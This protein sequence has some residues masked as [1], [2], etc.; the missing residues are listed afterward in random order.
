MTIVVH[1]FVVTTGLFLVGD[2]IKYLLVSA[3]AS[4]WPKQEGTYQVDNNPKTHTH[5]DYL[6]LRLRTLKSNLLVTEDHLHEHLNLRY[7]L[8]AVDL[9]L[10]G[11]YFLLLMCLV[12]V[13]QD[14]LL[15]YNT[16]MMT[17]LFS[18]NQ[19]YS[20]GLNY[21][22]SLYQTY[23][24]IESA[25]INSFN[26]N[27]TETGTHGWIYGD[28]NSKLGVV[29]LRQIRRKENYHLGWNGIRYTSLAYMPKWEL[30]YKRMA[31]TDKYW[32]IY[33]PWLPSSVTYTTFE[34]KFMNFDH[35]G[36]F[37]DYPE[38]A[39][40]ITMLAR[41][42]NNSMKVLNYLQANNWLTKETIV[43][44]LD[45]TLYNA[46]ANIFS[47]CTFLL[48]QTPFGT[49]NTDAH[50][51]SVKMQILDQLGTLG[52]TIAG[53][54]AFILIRF[55][56]TLVVTIWYE[57]AK[58]HNMWNKM[59][60]VILLLN[61]L[62]A[63]LIITQEI[64]VSHLLAKVEGA[65]KLEFLDFRRPAR[66]H[67][68]SS[69]MI[70]FLVCLTTLRLWKVLQFANVFQLFSAALYS[71][72]QA[73][74]S[75]AL[76]IVIFL[77]AFGFAV[78]II[79]GNNTGNFIHIYRSIITSLCFS[80]GF[81][82]H[83][84]PQ[85]LF[86]GGEIIGLILYFLLAFVLAQLLINVFVSTI[87]GYFQYAKSFRDARYV[88][89]INFL[90]FLRVEY[91]HILNHLTGKP[92]FY[93]SYHRN[94]RTVAENI[95]II[96]DQQ[97]RSGTKNR[98]H[99]FATSRQKTGDITDEVKKQA[100]YKRRIGRLF[101]IASI[102]QTQMEILEHLWLTTVEER[103]AA[104]SDSDEDEEPGDEYIA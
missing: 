92:F 53:L 83:V 65:S 102:M 47:I 62:V 89:R 97:Q 81:S 28:H 29:R 18:K 57:P 43:L 19:T 22:Q 9:W 6:K 21:V 64:I 67:T 34:K 40:Y 7:Q 20:L 24:F 73:L 58:L 23:Q 27:A 30:P 99:A 96:L 36:Y 69:I 3:D 71:A 60:L 38:F 63:A 93:R 39:G 59:D 14:K 41:T 82:S 25:L 84:T 100:E 4:A 77:M 75:T 49:V 70:G 78:A 32:H 52:F 66:L 11:T 68:L 26:P 50:V 1:M 86:Y 48:E 31:Y 45:F 35:E 104:T 85:D 88:R 55:A 44:F 8:I 37:S 61:V 10:Y 94:N 87:N 91:A 72:W 98:H 103:L 2:A 12:L 33:E 5:T 74:A 80:F 76:I 79:N 15:Y 54:Y 46:D 95:K 16:N 90:Q 56:K 13:S 42:R 101:T 17:K 51:L